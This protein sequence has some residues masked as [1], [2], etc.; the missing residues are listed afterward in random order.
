MELIERLRAADTVWQ[1]SV[2]AGSDSATQ[3]SMGLVEASF[4]LCGGHS[5]NSLRCSQ[6][7][8]GAESPCRG[9]F[10]AHRRPPTSASTVCD[11]RSESAGSTNE[12]SH[13]VSNEASVEIGLLRA[14]VQEL[15]HSSERHQAIS[16]NQSSKIS[17][18]Y[19]SYQ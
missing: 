10:G 9:M 8:Q 17:R 6:V 13:Q 4:S 7:K 3:V 12:L 11:P 19:R 2:A 5:S 16:S 18:V 14:R 1:N 15:E